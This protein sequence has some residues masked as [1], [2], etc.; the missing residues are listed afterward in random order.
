M[1]I[2]SSPYYDNGFSSGADYG[3][4]RV[5]ELTNNSVPQQVDQLTLNFS[6]LSN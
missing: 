4:V 6:T 5:F 2:A 3:K 1:V